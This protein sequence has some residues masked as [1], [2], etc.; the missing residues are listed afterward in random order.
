MFI[1]DSL[2]VLVT[3]YDEAN[4]Q[5]GCF[6]V[7]SILSLRHKPGALN[8]L[9]HEDLTKGYDCGAITCTPEQ[10]R[11]VDRWVTRGDFVTVRATASHEFRF[12]F[13][14]KRQLANRGVTDEDFAWL[15][16]YAESADYEYRR[17]I[18]A[19]KQVQETNN[20]RTMCEKIEPA[21]TKSEKTRKTKNKPAKARNE[22][23]KPERV[24][25]KDRRRVERWAEDWE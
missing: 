11:R 12:G 21:A 23:A 14:T 8:G 24:K 25:A 1:G 19:E 20:N 17:L 15:E 6:A 16:A 3:T 13:C 5:I 7:S 2:A 10:W 18:E 22:S 4:Q 9:P